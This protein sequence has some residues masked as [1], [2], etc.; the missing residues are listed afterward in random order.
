MQLKRTPF[1]E[2]H[3]SNSGRI[4]PFAGFEMP[5]QFQGIIPEHLRVR[6]T[7]GVFDV[8]HMGRA[9][10]RGRDAFRFV[11][12]MTTNDIA[13]T[14]FLQAQYSAFCYPDGGIVDDLL[15]YNLGDYLLLVINAANT[16]K[17]L[18]WLR[19]NIK[20][21]VKIV[22]KTA[23]TAQLAIQGPVAEPLVQKLTD[24]TL[25]PIPYYWSQNGSVAGV[26]ALISRTGY[27]G[28]DGF[29][30]Y[31][32]AGQALRVWDALFDAGKEWSLEPIGLGARDTLRLEMRYCLY[33]NDIDKT[34]NP[35]EAGLGWITKLDKPGGFIGQEV[36]SKIKAEG[37]KRKLVAFEMKGTEIPRH[38]FIIS[39]PPIRQ[40]VWRNMANGSEI[41]HVTSGTYSPSL[42]KGIGLGYVKTEFSEIGKELEIIIRD[43]PAAAAIVKPPF[44]KHATHK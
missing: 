22:D 44:Y 12:R 32:D 13:K 34:T 15:V 42:K 2:R 4:V 25:N 33:G 11:N 36:L 5:V 21:D 40:E 41:G 14:Q 39:N 24:I 38:G 31:F 1:Y 8:S 18:N 26:P 19:E 23:D 17:D 37:L 43:K 28:E 7:A 27:T 16:D 20:G 9:E 3:V 10:I 35:L 29:E 30:L 6:T